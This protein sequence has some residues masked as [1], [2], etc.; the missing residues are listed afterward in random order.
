MT[1]RVSGRATAYRGRQ[2]L[3]FGASDFTLS[4]VADLKGHQRISVCIPARDEEATVAG[5]VGPIRDILVAAGVV[6]ELLVLDDRSTD[7]TAQVAARAGAR[8]VPA[9]DVLPAAGACQGKGDV[10]WRSVAASTGDIIVW[11]DADLAAFDP[12][13]VLGLVGPLLLHEEVELVRAVYERSLDGVPGEGGRVTE[14]LARPVISALFPHLEHIRQ[15][16]G[17]EYAIRRRTAEALP[18]EVD[19]GVEIG[20]LIDVA[21]LHGVRAIA[22]VDVG[23]RTHRNRSIGALHEQSRQVLRAA[24]SRTSLGTSLHLTH[25][26]RPP[27]LEAVGSVEGP[28]AAAG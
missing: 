24:L 23:S 28:I 20:L 13:Y 1:D 10:L 26:P 6:D 19:Y 3:H 21:D 4:A 18:F 9:A 27:V 5:V 7:R 14:L 12:S 2:G 8:V 16:L 22:Q 17:G 25:P 15:P 11:L